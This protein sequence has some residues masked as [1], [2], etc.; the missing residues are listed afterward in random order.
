MRTVFMEKG[1]A[2]ASLDELAAA[3]GLNRPSLYAAFGDKEQLYIATLRFYGARS[4]DGLE[5]ILGGPGTIEQRLGKVYKAAIDLYTAPP[6]RPGCMIVGTAAVE[7]PSHPKIAAVANELLAAIE[8]SLER[9]F[10]ASGLARKPS[11]AARAH[12]AGAI[13]YA[14]A[15]RAR[16]G[17]KAADLKAF[18]ASMVP[19]ICA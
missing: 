4:V 8:K 19:A 15:I 11:P 7:S 6:H 13:L 9:A 2:A 5:A 1:F 16:L 14:I 18:A 12:M 3:S 17:A 10:A